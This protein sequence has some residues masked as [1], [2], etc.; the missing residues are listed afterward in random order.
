MSKDVKIL[1]LH[2]FGKRRGRQFD[3]LEEELK[4]RYEILAPDYYAL[5]KEDADCGIWMEN[6]R[7]ILEELKDERLIV[8]G[9]SLG[10]LMAA[11]Y[12]KEYDFEKMIFIS[13]GFDDRKFLEVK[14]A[15]PD[16]SVPA[17]YI[18]VFSDVLKSCIDD[19]KDIECPVTIIHSKSDEL[20]PYGYSVEYYDKIKS[21]HKR[22][23][24]LEGGSHAVLDD[25]SIRGK[26]MDILE[27]ELSDYARGEADD[28][29]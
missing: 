22:L 20:I 13:P 8:I 1:C 10:A 17:G 15:D 11:H 14:L 16:P 19:V 29:E 7:K 24:L 5:S 2:G 9:F 26:V 28:P 18:Q 27:D 23:Y 3:Y 25:L 12:A 6:V 21:E 4:D